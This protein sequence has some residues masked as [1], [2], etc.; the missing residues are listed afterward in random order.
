M[1]NYYNYFEPCALSAEFQH[2]I[3]RF[4]KT[5]LLC[6]TSSKRGQGVKSGPKRGWRRDDFNENS[7]E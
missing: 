4:N 6:R 2:F 1:Y 3:L 5:S 7:I